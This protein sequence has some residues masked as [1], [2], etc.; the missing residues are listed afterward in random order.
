[1]PIPPPWTPPTTCIP[2]SP[3][4]PCTWYLLP[5]PRQLPTVEFPRVH[6]SG[7]TGSLESVRFG[8]QRT[9]RPRRPFI[10]PSRLS[11]VRTVSSSNPRSLEASKNNKPLRYV[12]LNSRPL[13]RQVIASF[14]NFLVVR[15]LYIHVVVT[16]VVVAM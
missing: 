6:P 5:Y 4:D 13:S 12:S 16:V 9:P 15:Y 14:G 10:L 11:F 3:R 7:S 8:R 2:V 1:M